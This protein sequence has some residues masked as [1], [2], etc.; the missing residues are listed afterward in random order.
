MKNLR[1]IC[2]TILTI[3]SFGCKNTLHSDEE[4]PNKVSSDQ[5]EITTILK[6]YEDLEGLKLNDSEKWKV[7]STTWE[8]MNQINQINDSYN[9]NDVT[10]L[11]KEIKKILNQIINECKMTGEDHN[12]YHIV[13]HA[14]LKDS[15]KLVSGDLSTNQSIADYLAVFYYFF[16]KE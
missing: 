1:I 6:K 11:G 12:Q 8:Y 15:K 4:S 3:S 14:L 13:L 2:F 5:T 16:D 10:E 9:G 7:D